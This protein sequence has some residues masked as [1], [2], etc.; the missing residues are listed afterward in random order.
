MSNI[1]DKFK[2]LMGEDF[3]GQTDESLNVIDKMLDLPDNQ[4][5][6]VYPKLKAQ[7][8]S[9]LKTK[10]FQEQMLESLRQNPI[11][12]FDA[13]KV[14][15]TDFIEDIKNEPGLSANK[16]ELMTFM[17]ENTIL[18]IYELYEV[19]RE[20]VEVGIKK[21][22]NDA[23]LPTYAHSAD[24]GADVYA[25]EDTVLESGETKAVKTGIAISVPIGYEIQLRPRSG[26]SL[27]TGL[28]VAN[29]PATI[30]SGFLGEVGV[31]IQNTSS[32][33]YTIK[34]GDRIAQMVLAEVP[35]IKWVEV[36]DLGSSERGEGGYGSTG[37]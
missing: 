19:P 36:D 22:I 7:L 15:V 26:L 28:R 5:D 17:L 23:I 24:A 11:K 35:M 1:R 6:A 12:N 32:E 18:A 8:S 21:L 20:K 4:F 3:S 27:K 13:E 10:K 34:K 16:K 9:V 30:D 29:S 25:V 37:E 31:I 33:S 14:V 2:M